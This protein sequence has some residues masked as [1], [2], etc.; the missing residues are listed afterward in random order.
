MVPLEGGKTQENMGKMWKNDENCWFYMV[1][2]EE[3]GK[4]NRHKLGNE[5]M[6]GT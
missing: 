6:M 1:L 2:W 5:K 3:N 4:F